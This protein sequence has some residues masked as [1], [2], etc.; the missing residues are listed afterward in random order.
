MKSGFEF[1]VINLVAI[2]FIFVAINLVGLLFNFN[3]AKYVAESTVE[4]IEHFNGYTTHAKK[5]IKNY[6]CNNCIY[7]VKRVKD[8]YVVNITFPI[9]IAFY[10][11]KFV[12]RCG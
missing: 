4:T 6:E 10:R 9:K 7:K 5:E 2:S 8:R 12:G 3:Q 1:A 11:F